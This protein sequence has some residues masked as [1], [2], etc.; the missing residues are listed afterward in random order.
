MRYHRLVGAITQAH[1]QLR[2]STQDRSEETYDDPC[3]DGNRAED[4]LHE[5]KEAYEKVCVKA[6]EAR[7][8]FRISRHA[9]AFPEFAPT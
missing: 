9:G 5:F 1:R 7:E 6:V 8:K 4:P 3:E 2:T